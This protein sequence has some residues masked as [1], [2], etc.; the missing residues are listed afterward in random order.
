[1][2]LCNIIYSKILMAILINNHMF[3]MLSNHI[4]NTNMNIDYAISTLIT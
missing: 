3:E 2:L 1:M 4:I